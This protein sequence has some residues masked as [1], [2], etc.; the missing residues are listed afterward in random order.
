MSKNCC[1]LCT[2]T[3]TATETYPTKWGRLHGS[4]YSIMML[5]IWCKNVGLPE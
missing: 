5:A 1:W 3:T 4:N 2:T